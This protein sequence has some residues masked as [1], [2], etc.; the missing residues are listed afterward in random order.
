MYYVTRICYVIVGILCISLWTKCMSW[1]TYIYIVRLAFL[2]TRM[3]PSKSRPSP[4]C[5][6]LHIFRKRNSRSYLETK[7]ITASLKNV[8][9]ACLMR[10][11]DI[12][13]NKSNGSDIRRTCRKLL[14][15]RAS[16]CAA[17][18]FI[19]ERFDV[20][21]V[22]P[23]LPHDYV[24]S[25]DDISMYLYRAHTS[26]SLFP[27]LYD[28]MNGK[29]VSAKIPLSQLSLTLTLD[30]MKTVC[31]LHNINLPSSRPKTI[32]L[33]ELLN[34]HV[35]NAT[36]SG[37]VSV[38]YPMSGSNVEDLKSRKRK[39]RN[40]TYV[41]SKRQA[42]KAET[43]T[44][45]AIGSEFNSG[46]T[47]RFPPS[48]VPTIGSHAAED[49]IRG[50][51]A[52]MSADA[53]QEEGCATCGRLTRSV[54]LETIDKF[55]LTYLSDWDYVTC[56][57]RDS[58]YS[59]V[60]SIVGPVLDD[61]CRGICPVCARSIR[62]KQLPRLSLANGLWIGAVPPELKG[63]TFVEKLLVSRVR[64]NRFVF[65]VELS[66]HKRMK[67]N[68]IL[69]RNP[70]AEI[71][72]VLPPPKDDIDEVIAFIFS[73]PAR[74][75]DE[76]MRRLPLLVRRNKVILAL[77]WLKLNHCD[78]ADVGIS[79]NNL[80]TYKDGEFSFQY[81]YRATKGD[82]GDGH[83]SAV[84]VHNTEGRLGVEEGDCPFVVHG[85]TG[86]D[87]GV[88]TKSQMVA[89]AIKHLDT[90]GKVLQI[91]HASEPESI[92]NNPALYPQIF[93]WLFPYGRGGFKMNFKVG[94]CRRHCIKNIC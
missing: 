31:I 86:A 13:S 11:G 12:Y 7:T 68:A 71:Y 9:K 52:E 80:R 83:P 37:L 87:L 19:G 15:G 38:L 54:L 24:C 90:H 3:S 25:V 4:T 32:E 91:G 1:C 14:G 72:K 48:S 33:R 20:N 49:I 82:N 63:M 45:P 85:L 35:C 26:E 84:S 93:P 46:S 62:A 89:A 42:R 94:P 28:S 74:P 59:D 47:S 65:H 23:H 77:N 40:E 8:L 58:E 69:F 67:S 88:M 81:F 61:R 75:D 5:R 36:C 6:S 57:S 70:T 51:C 30:N 22:T 18:D 64:Y 76:T 56:K 44:D 2:V 92:F 10:S 27:I 34:S 29:C 60:G 17:G 16:L 78:Y 73:G 50:F 39:K 55:D 43:E 53:I 21:E 41:K 66:G 79:E